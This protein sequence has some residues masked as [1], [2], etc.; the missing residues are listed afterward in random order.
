MNNYKHL[1]TP[2]KV[3]THTYKNRIIA[4]PIYCGTFLNIPGLDYVLT[5]AMEARA[6]GG[7]AQVTLGETPVDFC[8]ASREPFPPINYANFNDPTMPKLKALVST[9]R[10]HGAKCLIELSHCGE[11]VEPIPGVEFGMGPMGYTRPDGL[12]IIAMDEEKMEMVIDHFIT[13]A[14]FMQEAGMDGVMIHAGHGWLLHQFLSPRTNRRTDRYGGSLENRSRFPLALLKAVREAMGPDF[15]LE[16]RVSGDECEEGGMKPEETAAFCHMAEEYVDLI[17]VSV[18]TYRNPILSG[19]FSSLFQPHGLNADAAAIVKKAVSVPVAVVGG[20]NDPA[21]ADKLLDEG[22]CDLIALAR[23]LTADPDFPNKAQQGK[24]DDINPCLR[25]YKCYLG[26]LEGVPISELPYLFGCTAN[27]AE[28]FYD[29]DTLNRKAEKSKKVLVVGGGVAGM[30]AA[31]TACDQGHNVTLAERSDKLGGVLFFTDKDYYKADL[32]RLKDVLIHRVENRN[33]KVLL[34]TTV[35]AENIASFDAEEVILA[36]GA[37]PVQPKIPG[38]ENALQA[39]D[40]YRPGH[41]VGKRVVM[42]GGGLVGC[43]TGLDLAHAGHEVTIL[44]MGEKPAPDAYPMHRV[45][46]MDEMEKLLRVV[47]S[48]RV[49]AI[50]PEGVTA[51]DQEGNQLSFP[52]DTVVYALGMK[53]RREDAEA[54]QAAAGVPVH[55][56]GD[57][58]RA[59]KVYEAIREGFTVAKKL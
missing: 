55:E 9:I 36:L 17:H 21:F 31:I 26:P 47:C 14:K 20:I 46:L 13:A 44:E 59:A 57:C 11:S 10:S 37:E 39:L 29:L 7:A 16:M 56:I 28:F 34:N 27:P 3:G 5:H 54:L 24:A 30:Q 41:T 22:K 18:G 51:V 1:F 12:E 42:V 48:A 52:A 25:C 53:A 15:I 2:L 23:Q 40:V 45:G 32:K 33:I 19:E 43:E 38:I 8:G 49:T 58:V 4:A 6:A 50:T 35:T